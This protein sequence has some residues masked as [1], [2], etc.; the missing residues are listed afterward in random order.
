MEKI[1]HSK[2][3]IIA[4]EKANVLFEGPYTTS[5]GVTIPVCG[6]LER[7]Y[8]LPDE[9]GA[10][11]E[12]LKKVVKDLKIDAILGCQMNGIPFACSVAT[13]LKIPF[14]IVRKEISNHGVRSHIS[15]NIPND[16]RNIA[17]LDDWN[18]SWK[19]L[20]YYLDI[21]KQ[22]GIIP[23]NIISV[24]DS[25]ED[26]STAERRERILSENNINFV[27]L[28]SFRDIANEFCKQNKISKEVLDLILDFVKDPAVY[29]DDDRRMKKFIKLKMSG[30]AFLGEDPKTNLEKKFKI[31]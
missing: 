10:V 15:G 5:S 7:I 2:K 19:T 12:D 3:T 17:L 28:C 30:N 31:S 25:F 14:A 11:I 20:E 24:V 29:V 4:L 6:I 8:G 23:K 13:E 26:Y 22:Y 27:A 21:V 16:A 18:G 1:I 9:Y